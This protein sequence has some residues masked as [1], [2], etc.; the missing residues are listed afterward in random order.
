[1]LVAV[2]SLDRPRVTM[3]IGL[4]PAQPA[5]RALLRH[6]YELY[7]YD[8]SEMT[9]GDIGADGLFTGDEFLD[10]W[11]DDRLIYLI[12]VDDQWAGFAWITRGSYVDPTI[13]D[14]YLID[15]FLILR[16]YRRQG[17]GEQAAVRLFNRFPGTWEV[18][19]IPENSGAQAFWRKVIG[20]FTGDHFEERFA[21]NDRWRGPVQ[22]FQST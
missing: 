11:P 22:V 7:A 6:L 17:I 1:M 16:R 14:H 3:K 12:K 13:D 18:G 19:E 8:F 20:R 2:W 15:E 21:D 4:L 10:P 9:H 5:H